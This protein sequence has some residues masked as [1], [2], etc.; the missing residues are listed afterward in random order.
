MTDAKLASLSTDDGMGKFKGFSQPFIRFIPRL[1]NHPL[2]S[3]QM[4]LIGNLAGVA[5]GC[6]GAAGF[7]DAVISENNP[8]WSSNAN[9]LVRLVPGSPRNKRILQK[10]TLLF[11]DSPTFS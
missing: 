10:L 3:H 9:I 7:L 8:D 6:A 4:N 11:F 2:F 1:T 5:G